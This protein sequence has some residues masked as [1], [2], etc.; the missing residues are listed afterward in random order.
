MTKLFVVTSNE[1]PSTFVKAKSKEEARYKFI[2]GLINREIC[3]GL[4]FLIREVTME[5]L[6]ELTPDQFLIEKDTSF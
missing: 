3:N 5:L 4:T 2:D 1:C 6:M